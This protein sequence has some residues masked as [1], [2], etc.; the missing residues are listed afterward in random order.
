[1]TAPAPDRDPDRIEHARLPTPEE[2]GAQLLAM[3]A[4]ATREERWDIAR[5]LVAC[6][7]YCVAG[8]ALMSWAVH[9]TDLRVAGAAF[10][11]GLL[12]GN[13]GILLTLAV[14]YLRASRR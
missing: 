3:E 5:T 2:R 6:V 14:A 12:V 10:W 7:V 11:S 1:M 8:L 13:G 4:E 9:T